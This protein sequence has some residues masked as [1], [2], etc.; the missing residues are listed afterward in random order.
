MHILKVSMIDLRKIPFTYPWIL[1][2]AVGNDCKTV[3]DVGCG[4]GE[5]M[6]GVSRGKRWI[7]TGIDVHAPTLK[8][9]KKTKIYKKLVKGDLTKFP[10]EITKQKYDLV[11]C[12][13]VVEHLK[14][15]DAKKLIKQCELVAKKRVMI[16]TTVGFM[17]FHPLDFSDDDK[18]NP[19]QKHVSG[20]SVS[21]FSKTG[22]NVHGQ[23][24]FLIYRD[25]YLAHKLPRFFQPLLL[26]VSMI[27][28]PVVYYLPN[29]GTYQINC[30]KINND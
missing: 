19:F 4:S 29:L 27:A 22:Y 14:K 12:S 5:T 24:L 18:N 8:N 20:W 16:S 21:D 7:I 30:K 10:K 13:Q 11:F 2:K 17:K 9:A 15:K 25:G 23:G 28:S 1:D 6:R 3:L 26:L